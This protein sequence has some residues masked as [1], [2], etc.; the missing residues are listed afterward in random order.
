MFFGKGVERKKDGV[1]DPDVNGYL[2]GDQG[3]INAVLQ[4][5]RRRVSWISTYMT[6]TIRIICSARNN[7]LAG[8]QLSSSFLTHVINAPPFATRF[9][10]RS[11]KCT[12]GLPR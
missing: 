11:F 6:D 8:D 5:R 9:V 12:T 2:S 7:A 1:F 3:Y 4:V 10:R